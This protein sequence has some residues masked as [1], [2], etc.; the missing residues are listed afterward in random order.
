MSIGDRGR[1]TKTLRETYISGQENQSK[2]PMDLEMGVG[3]GNSVEKK[4]GEVTTIIL[5]MN[6]HNSQAYH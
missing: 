4:A 3:G 1:G 5:Y 6:Q 2:K